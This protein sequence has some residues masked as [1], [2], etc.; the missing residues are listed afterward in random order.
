V[1]TDVRVILHDRGPGTPRQKVDIGMLTIR[2]IMS[3]VRRCA[4]GDSH[5]CGSIMRSKFIQFGRFEARNHIAAIG[6]R[7]RR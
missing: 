6:D 4:L 2:N 1:I 7:A 5:A 3:K